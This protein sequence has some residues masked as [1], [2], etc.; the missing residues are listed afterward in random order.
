M[1]LTLM[2]SEKGRG[3]FVLQD[4]IDTDCVPGPLLSAGLIR[5][6]RAPDAKNMIMIFKE[7][8]IGIEINFTN[9]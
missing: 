8:T 4:Y 5:R 6:G 7:L 2:N 1:V 3:P 9:H